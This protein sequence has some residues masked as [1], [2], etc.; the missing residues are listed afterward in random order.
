VASGLQ[1]QDLGEIDVYEEVGFAEMMVVDVHDVSVTSRGV[2]DIEFR[3]VEEE[4]MKW[5]HCG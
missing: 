5:H 3:K 1:D 4:P 2:M